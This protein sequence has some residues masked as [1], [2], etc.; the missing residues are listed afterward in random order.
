MKKYIGKK[1]KQLTEEEQDQLLSNPHTTESEGDCIVDLTENLSVGGRVVVTDEESYIEIDD[2]AIIYDPS[3]RVIIENEKFKDLISLK[4]ASIM[5]NKEEST[6][7]RNIKNGLFIEWQ[8][9]V[10][11]G[12]QWVFDIKALERV[13]GKL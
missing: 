1:W 4:D 2:D 7:R 13:Y 3:D 9:C 11:F 6:L 12:K 5:F 8:D 10:K